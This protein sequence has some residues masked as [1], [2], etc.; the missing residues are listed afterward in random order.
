MVEE[1]VARPV[2]VVRAV[3]H[4]VAHCSWLWLR[5]MVKSQDTFFSIFRLF[6]LSRCKKPE[7]K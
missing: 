4:V 3:Q 7:A 5:L 2:A 1:T 6:S